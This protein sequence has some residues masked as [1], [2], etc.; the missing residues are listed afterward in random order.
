MKITDVK[1]FQT[2]GAYATWTFVKLY[3]D[4][5]LTGVGEAT[6]EW[7]DQSLKAQIEE[8]GDLI[9]GQDPHQIEHIWTL[10]HRRKFW[11]G[12]PLALSAISGIEQALW[13]IKGKALGVPVYQ[14]LGGKM[15]DRIRLYANGWFFGAETPQDFA[16]MAKETVAQGFTPSFSHITPASPTARV[17]S[18]R[19]SRAAAPARWS[20]CRAMCVTAVCCAGACSDA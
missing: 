19:S 9:L 8:F 4:S 7:K 16:R 17:L 14:L 11:G 1:V 2:E 6:L 18:R 15:R 20:S 13:D 10:L 12:G 3:T 5:N